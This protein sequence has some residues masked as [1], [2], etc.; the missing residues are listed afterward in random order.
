MS[1]VET[2]LDLILA[3]DIYAENTPGII[4]SRRSSSSCENSFERDRA[5]VQDITTLAL[6]ALYDLV[7]P[8]QRLLIVGMVASRKLAT[9][10][11]LST[12]LTAAVEAFLAGEPLGQ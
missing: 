3:W 5:I 6:N 2:A 8:S 10:L 4:G 9:T 11:V 1:V 12:E 7:I